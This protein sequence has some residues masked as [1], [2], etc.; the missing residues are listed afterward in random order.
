MCSTAFESLGRTQ[1]RALGYPELPLAIIPHPFGIRTR[2]EV[3]A[4]A[5]KCVDDIARLVAENG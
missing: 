5:A 1:A 2:E 3:R 4:I